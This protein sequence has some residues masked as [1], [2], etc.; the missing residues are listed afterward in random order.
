MPKIYFIEGNIGTGKSTFLK[1]VESLN[2]DNYQVIYEPVDIWTNFK[3]STG[4]N[5]L[6]YFYEDTKRFAYT[7]QNTAFIS[8]VE[9]LKEIDPTKEAVF[10]ERSIWSD[11]NVFA[12]NC[13][14]S[15]MMNEI[16]YMLYLKWFTWLE[17]NLKLQGT[18]EFVY[19]RCS[20]KTSFERMKMRNRSEE[21]SVSLE[22][23]TQIHDKHEQWLKDTLQKD[24]VIILNAEEDIKKFD[25]FEEY[26]DFVL[27]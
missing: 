13:F 15:Q 19:L 9:K 5:I 17:E 24:N 4:K 10:I 23:L 2:N 20:P 1:M 7:F 6:Q 27:S 14:E 18:Y 12:K 21:T 16:E 8:R 26:I 25:V 11:K 22:Y 3:D